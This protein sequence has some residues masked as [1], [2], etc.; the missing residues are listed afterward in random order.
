MLTRSSQ[1]MEHLNLKTLGGIPLS[2]PFIIGIK[3]LCFYFLHHYF[4]IKLLIVNYKLFTDLLV[5]KNA[6][7]L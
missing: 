2:F 3:S 6:H 1:A 7:L 4:Q 5:K